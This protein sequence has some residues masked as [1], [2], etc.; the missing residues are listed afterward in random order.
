MPESPGSQAQQSGKAGFFPGSLGQGLC[1]EAPCH[2]PPVAPPWPQ[3]RSEGRCALQ[4]LPSPHGPSELFW[5]LGFLGEGLPRVASSSL[6]PATREEKIL[7]PCP[8]STDPRATAMVNSPEPAARRTAATPAP[9]ST[10]TGAFARPPTSLGSSPSCDHYLPTPTAPARPEFPP[11]AL[12]PAGSLHAHHARR[13]PQRSSNSA[14]Y[15]SEGSP[16][17]SLNA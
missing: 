11:Q 2:C 5:R 4:P 9:S 16:V 8:L 7:G 10:L 1:S 13:T 15:P 17:P 6:C 14:P 12:H 3:L